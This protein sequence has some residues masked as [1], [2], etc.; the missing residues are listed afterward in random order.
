MATNDIQRRIRLLRAARVLCAVAVPVEGVTLAGDL[1]AGL[2]AYAVMIA[3]AMMGALAGLVVQTAGIRRLRRE[4]A[5]L[6]RNARRPDYA[7]IARMERE[8]W[9]VAFDHAGAPGT[10]TDGEAPT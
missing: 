8:V 10:A 6:L 4:D 5:R 1:A 3:F 2:H 9:G 7:A